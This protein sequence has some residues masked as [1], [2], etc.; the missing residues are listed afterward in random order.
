MLRSCNSSVTKPYNKIKSRKGSKIAIISVTRKMMRVIYAM[1][2][3]D[4]G[5][6][7]EKGASMFLASRLGQ[8][9]DSC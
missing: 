7:S 6:L 8:G 5:W 4:L 9:S 2:K 3:E 1:L